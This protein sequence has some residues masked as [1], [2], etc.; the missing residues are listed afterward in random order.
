MHLKAIQLYRIG[1]YSGQENTYEN[2]KKTT[3]NPK[4]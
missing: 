1:S 3:K 4:N 2:T